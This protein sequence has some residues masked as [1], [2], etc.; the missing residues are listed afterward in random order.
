MK[1]LARMLF[2]F[3]RLVVRVAMRKRQRWRGKAHQDGDQESS[4]AR[5]RRTEHRLSLVR[6][7]NLRQASARRAHRRS[8]CLRAARHR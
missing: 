1:V 7:W 5:K 3:V 8:R 2:V 6:C 4:D